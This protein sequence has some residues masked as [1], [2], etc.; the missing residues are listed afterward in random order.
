M[1]QR[2]GGGLDVS[3]NSRFYSGRDPFF[4]LMRIHERMQHPSTLQ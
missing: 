3:A 2:G 1:A 4:F